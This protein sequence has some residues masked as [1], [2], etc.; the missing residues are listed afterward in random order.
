[1]ARGDACRR[2]P[3]VSDGMDQGAGVNC[4]E[5]RGLIQDELD[6]LLTA[7]LSVHLRAHLASCPSCAAEFEVLLAIDLALAGETL[8]RAPRGLADAVLSEVGRRASSRG[9]VERIA[10]A[11]GVPAG[12]VSVGLAI[13]AVVIARGASGATLGEAVSR[14]LDTARD[15]MASFAGTA[16]FSASWSLDPG[17]QGILWALAAA[18]LSLLAL[19]ALRISRQHVLEWN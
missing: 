2:W 16:G 9:L 5:T 18:A 15:A 1:M 6:G 3:T 14:S 13:R 17:A 11:A 8:A 4:E 10:T 19:T 12:L 7:E